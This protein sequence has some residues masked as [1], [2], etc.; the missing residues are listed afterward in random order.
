M[1]A[2]SELRTIG[3]VNLHKNLSNSHFPHK[4]EPCI[5]NNSLVNLNHPLKDRQ[6]DVF[7]QHSDKNLKLY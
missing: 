2:R 6:T 7:F 4:N 1:N 3:L 5:S